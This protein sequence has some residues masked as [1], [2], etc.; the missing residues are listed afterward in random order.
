MTKGKSEPFN[1]GNVGLTNAG[2]NRRGFLKGA[3][4]LGL[5]SASGFGQSVPNRPP[6]KLPPTPLKAGGSGVVKFNNF[7]TTGGEPTTSGGYYNGLTFGVS[8]DPDTGGTVLYLWPTTF[9][10]GRLRVGTT[11]HPKGRS[12]SLWAPKAT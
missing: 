10:R 7:L 12:A 4:G 1:V 3:T 8:A 9:I 2:L 5:F 6:Q 11:F